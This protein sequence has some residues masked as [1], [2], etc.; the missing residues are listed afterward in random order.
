M[1]MGVDGTS[2]G[3][4]PMVGFGISGVDPSGTFPI[5]VVINVVVI[6]RICMAA[7]EEEEEEEDKVILYL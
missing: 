6:K 1:G 5:L 2:S 7:E 4:C 3:S